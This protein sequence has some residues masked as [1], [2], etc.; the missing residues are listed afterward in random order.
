MSELL[1]TAADSGNDPDDAMLLRVDSLGADPLSPALSLDAFCGPRVFKATASRLRPP[2]DQILSD[3]NA[4]RPRPR[5]QTTLRAPA[6]R[7]RGVRGEIDFR[8]RAE[9][10]PPSPTERSHPF[11]LSAE[12]PASQR[13]A[14]TATAHPTKGANA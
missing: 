5:A 11:E 9:I 3:E 14:G 13:S 8:K 2:L 12:A 4:S 6:P 1:A 7:H 10:S